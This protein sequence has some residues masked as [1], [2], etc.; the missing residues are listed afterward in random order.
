MYDI[1]TK[2]LPSSITVGGES[3]PIDTDFRTW[4][5][6]VVQVQQDELAGY[7][8][9]T[10]EVPQDPEWVRAAADFAA[11]RSETPRNVGDGDE[12]RIF[13][14]IEDGGR[15][16]AAFQQVY[17]IDLTECDMHWWRFKMLLDNLPEG[18]ALGQVM[19][20]RAY[21]KPSESKNAE[22]EF[23][24]RMKRAY[25]LPP[26]RTSEAE[27]AIEQQKALFGKLTYKKEVE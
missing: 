16:V 18:T 20:Y 5:R 10:G 21:R 8:I 14:Y 23:H 1:R 19:G 9:F 13:D 27:A 15:I 11:C 17:G 2:G 25:S 12:T 22:H 26:L 4:I 24:A 3:F 7:F 6:W